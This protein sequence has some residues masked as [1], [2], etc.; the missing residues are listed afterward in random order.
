MSP[1]LSSEYQI[2]LVEA[3]KSALLELNHMLGAFNESIVLVGGW[4]PYFLI[5]EYGNGDFLHV[6]SIDIDLAIDPE[7]IDNDAYA[8]I[9]D[10]IE[11]QG[12]SRRSNREGNPILFIQYHISF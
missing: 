2:G 5:E 3:S 10:R 12:Y 11:D 1:R 8:G 6:G 4:A 9:I 7:T